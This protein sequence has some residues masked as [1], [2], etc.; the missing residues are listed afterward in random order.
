MKRVWTLA[1][2]RKTL[3]KSIVVEESDRREQWSS[4][5]DQRFEKERVKYRLAYLLCCNALANLAVPL[6]INISALALV[7]AVRER[8]RRRLRCPS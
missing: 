2:P 6:Q 5:S 3:P 8:E 1:M 7:D 4:A